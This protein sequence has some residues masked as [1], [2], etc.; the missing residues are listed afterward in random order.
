MKE[1]VL[2]LG[3][4][5]SGKSTFGE[6]LAGSTERVLFVA[7]A[8]A[9]DA[10]MS[11]KIALH[12]EQHPSSWRTVEE[13]IDLPGAIAAAREPFDVVLLDCMTLWVSN[14]LLRKPIPKN[15]QQDTLDR[16]HELLDVYELG[17]ARWIIVSNEVGLGI[18]PPTALGRLYRDVLGRV[19]QAIALRADKAYWL[20][21]G[22]ATELKA[23]GA[24]PISTD[25][26]LT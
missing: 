10:E 1:L 21:A 18:V 17:T 7:T 25:R 2:I 4:A 8:R 19:N 6:Q 3:G 26:S 20:V 22:L 5:R 16:T 15:P 23:L 12:K 13:P 11:R 9:G 14:L 24:K